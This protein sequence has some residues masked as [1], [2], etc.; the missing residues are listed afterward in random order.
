MSA[1]ISDRYNM[2]NL[3]HKF[4][5]QNMEVII[6]SLVIFLVYSIFIE[7]SSIYFSH[8]IKKKYQMNSRVY[9]CRYT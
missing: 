1:K 6:L 4:Y 5:V 9:I 3:E 2:T 7:V 8:L